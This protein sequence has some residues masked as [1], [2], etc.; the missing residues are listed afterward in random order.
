[1]TPEL[2]DQFAQIVGQPN[3]INDAVETAP[4]TQ[5]ARGRYAASSP[6]VLRPGSTEDVSAIVKLAAQTATAIIPQ[7][8]NTGLVGGGTPLDGSR[9]AVIISLQRLNAI[10]EIDTDTNTMLVQAGCVL[11]KIQEAADDVDRLFPLSLGAQG[12]C[13]IGGNIGSNA[14]G[15]GVLA[16]GNTR[17]LVMGLEVVLPG[18][19]VLNGLSKLRK[20]NTGYDL[21]NLFIGAEGTLGIVTRAV[22][23]LFSKPKGIAVAY[24]GLDSPEAALALFNRARETIGNG[25]TGFELISKRAMDFTLRHAATPVQPPLAEATP[26]TVLTEISSGQSV[27]DANDRMH[28]LL[29]TALGDGLIRDATIAQNEGQAAQ[30]WKLREDMSLAQKPEGASI[31]HD[32][33]VPVGAIP[34]F[35][36]EADQTV[37]SIVPDGRIVN[38]GHMGDG[39]LHYNITQ[40]EGWTA[41]RFFEFEETIH[42]A[43]YDLVTRHCGSISAE[44]GIGQMKRAALAR[45]KD[46]VALETMRVLKR[47]LDPGG[48]MNPGKVV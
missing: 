13:M 41:E 16:Y 18:G 43:I 47:T 14:G 1:M 39:N 8:G 44:H 27:Q 6:L 31:K 10:E 15:T 38:F 40:P 28:A 33:S 37:L 25:L 35:I 19:E 23:K 24:I 17:E 7:G 12:S 5:D 45:L 29:E 42:N 22:L 9:E 11:Q 36:K 2:I 26:W 46:P 20:D 4:Y 34:S 21:K 32:I 48:I 30:F 3:A